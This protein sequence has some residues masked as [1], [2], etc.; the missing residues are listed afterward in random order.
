MIIHIR[1]EQSDTL[2]RLATQ[3][4]ELLSPT[5][6]EVA[7]TLR[8]RVGQGCGQTTI[9]KWSEVSSDTQQ[10]IRSIVEQLTDLAQAPR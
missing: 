1:E 8:T 2:E 9:F 7:I 4:I 3:A 10:A 5:Q 6:E